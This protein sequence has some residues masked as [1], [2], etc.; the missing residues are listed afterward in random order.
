VIPVVIAEADRVGEDWVFF[1]DYIKWVNETIQE[2]GNDDWNQDSAV[3]DRGMGTFWIMQKNV[4][5]A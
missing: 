4:G 3:R 1:G 5:K 2:T